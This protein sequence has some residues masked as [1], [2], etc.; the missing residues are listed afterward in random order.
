MAEWNTLFNIVDGSGQAT[1]NFSKVSSHLH[2]DETKMI[3]FIA[4]DQEG[5]GIIVVDT[6]SSWPEA[7][8]V[9]SLQ[10]AITYE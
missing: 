5:L 7:A 10:E 3:F 8:S 6:T 4:P 2:G 1:E 9:G